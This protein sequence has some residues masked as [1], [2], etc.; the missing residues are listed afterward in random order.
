[1]KLL[2]MFCL[3]M[4]LNCSQDQTNQ[5]MEEMTVSVGQNFDLTLPVS[6]G[7]GYSWQLVSN[8]SFKLFDQKTLSNNTSDKDGKSEKQVFTLSALE[9]GTYELVF[10]LRRPWEKDAKNAE[11]KVFKVKVK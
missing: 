1:M 5:P 11:Q 9:K 3:S 4:L 6:L 2:C 10:E 7:T 8:N